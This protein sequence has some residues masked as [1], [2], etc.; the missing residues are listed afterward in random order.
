MGTVSPYQQ[1]MRKVLTSLAV[2]ALL[3]LPGATVAHAQGNAAVDEYSESTPGGGGNK[4][5][6]SGSGSGSSSG[7]ASSGPLTSAQ[8]AALEAQGRDGAAAA[9]LAQSTG[10]DGKGQNR[11]GAGSA[12]LTGGGGAANEPTQAQD[13]GGPGITEAIGDLAGGSDSGMGPVLPIVLIAAVM[14]SLAFVVVRR[15][16]SGHAGSA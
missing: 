15:R 5:S 12:G 13:S 10:P 8:I 7:D 6:N 3:A 2:L 11:E 1:S 14:G 9:A 16:G 4:P